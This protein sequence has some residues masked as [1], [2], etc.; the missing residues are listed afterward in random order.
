MPIEQYSSVKDTINAIHTRLQSVHRPFAGALVRIATVPIPSGPR[1]LAGT[2]VFSEQRQPDHVLAEYPTVR[3]V[4]FW[5]DGQDNA[6]SFLSRFWAGKETISNIPIPNIFN[7][8]TFN[9]NSDGQSTSGWPSWLF[10]ASAD[11]RNGEQ[12]L[13]LEQS[14]TVRKGLI[15]F[16]SPADAVRR[17]I[18]QEQGSDSMTN[19]VPY[20]EQFLTVVPDTR[21]RFA[22]G[23]WTPGELELITEVNVPLR[24]L[25]LQ[26]IH[27]G[28]E[29]RSSNYS[30]GLEPM[31]LEVPEDA[32]ELVLYLVHKN[33]DIVCSRS[34]HGLYRSFGK[35]EGQLDGATEVIQELQGGEN[36][37][38]EFKPYVSPR[39]KKEFDFV[40]TVVAFAN[41]DGGRI[42]VGVDDEGVPLGISAA[43]GCF[44]KTLDPIAAQ[45]ARLKR[46][47][48]ESTKPVPPVTYKN[49][50]VNGNPVI[51]AEVRRSPSICSTQDNRVYVRRGATS[52]LADPETELP[53]LLRTPFFDLRS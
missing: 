37:T 41:T 50:E 23:R 17:W 46:V 25:E 43:R 30:V 20:Q 44:K 24:D 12:R 6:V 27:V 51:V 13:F 21:A 35:F 1:F 48:T 11:S 52:R 34:L 38:R 18:F 4:Q 9:H 28:A 5:C 42:F 33:G 45:Q 39:D 53:S 3:F 10:T 26:I 16:R 40:K 36:E 29:H 19:D 14:A 32:R 8:A 15:P 22:S 2:M 49:V 7:H 31:I 47:I